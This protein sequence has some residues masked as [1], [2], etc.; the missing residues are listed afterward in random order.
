MT[1]R[2]LGWLS[3]VRARRL[4]PSETTNARFNHFYVALISVYNYLAKK[5][6]AL[7]RHGFN[8]RISDKKVRKFLTPFFTI[9]KPQKQ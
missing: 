1:I 6:S 2:E 8:S 9:C 7:A 5:F 4:E 3:T